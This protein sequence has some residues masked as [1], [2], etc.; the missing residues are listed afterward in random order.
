MSKEVLI[1]MGTAASLG[2]IHTIFGPDHYLPFIVMSKA[3]R[4][5]MF[6][7]LVI[8]F[9]C[10]VGHIASSVI[11]GLIGVALGA[12]VFKLEAIE[13]ARGDIAAWLLIIFGFTYFIWGLHR[14]F[15]N[16]PHGH[17]HVHDADQ[18]AHSHPHSHVSEHFHIHNLGSGA[19]ITPWVLFTIFIFGPC[20]PLIPLL[21]Y[22]AAKANWASVALVSTI[23]GVITIS[24]MLGMVIVFSYGLSRLSLGRIEKYSH[25]LA[26]FTIFL[27]GGAIKFLGL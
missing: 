15:R 24:T 3:R 17:S 13:A 19:N 18:K 2:F 10:G 12:A 21:M 22:P 1:L 9:L 16:K 25:A 11:L 26:G 6:K 7:T 5:N 27:C 4:W 23:F 20:E 8:T 14:A